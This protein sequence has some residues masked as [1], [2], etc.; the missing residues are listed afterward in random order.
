M[1]QFD[2]YNFETKIIDGHEFHKIG[3][4]SDFF[5][6]R[7]K[8]I[9]FGDDVDLQ[10]AV[11]RIDG[12]LYALSNICPHRHQDQIHNGILENGNV[13]CPLHGW[14][15]ELESGNNIN[16][17]QGIKSLKKFEITEIDGF[18]YVRKPDFDIPAWKMNAESI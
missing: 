7:G 11:F 9:E 5:E 14:T 16:F 13:I 3:K 1:D 12:I 17:K 4:S 18:V 8:K 6:K 15:Y 10:I 2:K